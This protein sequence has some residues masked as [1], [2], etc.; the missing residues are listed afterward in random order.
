MGANP[1]IISSRLAKSDGLPRTATSVNINFENALARLVK[2]TNLAKAVVP[3]IE[4]LI[5]RFIA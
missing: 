1:Q 2:D 5:N 3:F 4:Q